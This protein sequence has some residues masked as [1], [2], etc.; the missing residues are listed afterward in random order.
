M[1]CYSIKISC[2]GKM[3]YT[4]TA[5]VAKGEQEITSMLTCACCYCTTF[6]VAHA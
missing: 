6:K 1:V 2:T 5:Q 3:V 4:T